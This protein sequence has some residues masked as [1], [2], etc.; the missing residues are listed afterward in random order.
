MAEFA[1][2]K[3]DNQD[4]RNRYPQTIEEQARIHEMRQ[5]ASLI[6][7]ERSTGFLVVIGPCGL[8]DE[9]IE[10]GTIGNE[11]LDLTKLNASG[12]KDALWLHRMPDW[13]PRTKQADWHGL[14]TSNPELAYRTLR[15]SAHRAANVA[16]EINTDTR[17]KTDHLKRNA[18]S[19]TLAW[20]GGRNGTE[21]GLTRELA[22]HDQSLPIAV[23]NGL[24]GT[25]DMALGDVATIEELRGQSI[26][27]G[28]AARAILL[29]R[30]GE[31][32]MNPR[33]WEEQY[34][35][36]HEATGGRL[37][38]D[39]A[40]GTEMA[41]DPVEGR[42]KKSVQGQIDAGAHLLEIIARTGEAP[43]GIFMEASNH[44]GKTDPNMPFKE[45]LNIAHLLAEAKRAA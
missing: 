9:A 2:S 25:I 12:D 27:S 33:A 22:L 28:I 34:R 40:H 19:L 35:R 36:A 38:V 16:M 31:N 39:L 23:K 6:M 43:A 15:E 10:S 42:F 41:H 14:I 24:D 3:P 44:P 8:T 1:P 13:K 45:A 26:E 32:A 17:P 18:D 30:G 20:K 7:G 4:L 37:L 21:A 5:R 11:S 29:Y